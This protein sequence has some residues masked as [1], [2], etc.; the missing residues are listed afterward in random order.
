[1]RMRVRF[2]TVNRTCGRE[3]DRTCGSKTMLERL[4]KIGLP[5][6]SQL[7]LATLIA[8]LFNMAAL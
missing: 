7:P 2:E 6:S 3:N 8:P 1:M 4:W 5:R